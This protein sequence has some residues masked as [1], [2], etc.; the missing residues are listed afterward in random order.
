MLK[1]LDIGTDVISIGNRY[2]V[3]IEGSK[4]GFGKVGRIWKIVKLR[5]SGDPIVI[6]MVPIGNGSSLSNNAPELW[7]NIKDF[8]TGF[9]SISVEYVICNSFVFKNRL[10]DNIKC[11]VLHSFK[12][13]NV[14]VETEKYVKGSSCDGLGKTGHC[15][16]VP[17]NNLKTI[18]KSKQI[19]QTNV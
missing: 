8:R 16:V 19:K 9:I 12:D 18:S 5:C 17:R 10:L 13:G 4:Y 15:L 7:T 14:F 3:T 1:Q 2:R 11:E 6:G